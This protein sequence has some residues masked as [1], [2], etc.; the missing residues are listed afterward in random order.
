MEKEKKEEL[1]PRQGDKV[2]PK[3]GDLDD[4]QKYKVVQDQAEETERVRKAE[5]EKLKR[6]YKT[7]DLKD[8]SAEDVYFEIGDGGPVTMGH[9][10]IL[11]RRLSVLEEADDDTGLK[12]LDEMMPESALR[13]SKSAVLQP[14]AEEP[15]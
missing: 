7:T 11:A 12:R 13:Y 14:A 1:D 4:E 9:L 2:P 8:L 10:N 3:F 15:K 6:K 5:K